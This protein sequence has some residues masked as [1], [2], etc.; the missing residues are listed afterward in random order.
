MQ[1]YSS[2]Q[3]FDYGYAFQS[4]DQ[5]G[6]DPTYAY[7]V[8]NLGQI[9]GDFIG[10]DPNVAGNVAHGFFFN[11]GVWSYFDDP[12]SV[13]GTFAQGINDADQ[14]VGYYV[15]GNAITHGFIFNKP[16]GTYTTIDVPGALNSFVYGINDAGQIVGAYV[17]G[18]GKTH[19]FVGTAL[20]STPGNNDEWILSSGHW[21]ASAEPGSHPSGYQVV[22]VGDFFGTGTASI[23]WYNSSTGDA[24]E[25]DMSNGGLGRQRRSGHPSR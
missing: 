11:N 5:S 2:A 1:P 17:D 22:G 14:I 3:D 19:G 13:N 9:V 10:T 16:T 4:Q 25:W 12:N 8:N 15:D 24:D 6:G 7:G 21:A 23:L 18:S 20:P